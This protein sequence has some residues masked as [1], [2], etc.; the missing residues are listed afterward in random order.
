MLFVK[1]I[2]FKLFRFIVG[3]ISSAMLIFIIRRLLYGFLVILGV[4]V[5]I[6]MLFYALPGDPVT[7]MLGPRGGD[8][9]TRKAITK[10]FGLDKPLPVQLLYYLNDLSP[11]ALHEPSPEAKRKYEYSEL[12]PLG[13]YS[14]VAKQPYMRRSFMSNRRVDEMLLEDIEGT[15]IL[16]FVSMFFATIIGVIFGIFAALNQNTFTDYLLVTLS[17]LGISTPSFVLAIAIS[18][19]FGF[20]L[21]QYTGL[22]M[23]GTLWE[24][25]TMG[26]RELHLKNL[27]LPAFTLTLRPLA[28]I[29]Q[30]TRSSMLEV[31]SQDYI[32]TAKAKGLRYPKIIY[33][34][35]LKNALNPVITAVSGWLASLMAG[36]FF[37]EFIFGWKGLGRTTIE[38]VQT[39]DLPV[40]M[41]AT[42]VIAFIFVIVNIVVDILYGAID[43]RIR[44]Q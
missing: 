37:I 18:I 28:I 33:K 26:D 7:A 44:L 22:E 12:L 11:I 3:A 41:G 21:R 25:N 42:I 35:A 24:L 40:V 10:E 38:A 4:I 30:L 16:A 39:Q 9:A 43:P 19:I 2:F 36:A 15:L 1:N 23:Y 34:H 29:V 20:Y 8:E 13:H 14:L 31:L 32:R 27:I 17:V 5:V 6:F